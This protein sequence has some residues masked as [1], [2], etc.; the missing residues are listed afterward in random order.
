[1]KTAVFNAYKFERDYLISSNSGKHD[2]KLLEFHPSMDTV[3]LANSS[4][5]KNVI[6]V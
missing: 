4:D 2:L 3:D 5:N 6:K 1:M